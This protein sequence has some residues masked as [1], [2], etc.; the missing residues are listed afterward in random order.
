M[1]G[2]GLVLR[3]RGGMVADVYF[4][5][6]STKL[7]DGEFIILNE[8]ILQDPEGRRFVW[9]YDPAESVVHKREIQTAEIMDVGIRVNSGLQ[10]DEVIATAGAHYLNEGQKVRLQD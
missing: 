1:L 4:R 10:V 5:T 6:K 2:S 8:A 7:K 3:L 9:V